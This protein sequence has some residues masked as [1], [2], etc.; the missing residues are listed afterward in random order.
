LVK[1]GN[2]TMVLG[3]VNTYT[4]ATIVSN[5]TLRVDGSLA[6]GSAVTV[7]VG[8]LS[9]VGTINGTTA[10][11][12]GA[13]LVAG[14]AKI[15]TLT[16]NNNLTL[17]AA[18]T[19]LFMVTTLGGASNSVAVT[20]GTLTPNGSVIKINTAGD[21]NLGAGTNVLFTYSAISGSFN[22]TPVFV[23]P[24]TGLAT[25]AVLLDTGSAI[26]LAVAN[27]SSVN[28]N[29]TNIT[30]VVTGSTLSLTWPGDHLGWTLQTNSVDLANTNDWFPYPGSAS[31]T[32]VDIMIDPTQTNVFFRLVYP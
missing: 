30:A 5:G 13:Y 17:D 20:A 10:V 19:N 32:N 24:Q 28:T 25:N 31:V 11:N 12:A 3:G 26:E 29:P 7:A 9:G 14:D 18:S 8:I 1:T 16:F 27:L 4:S 2:G 23:T 6:A 15:G 22:A 21:A